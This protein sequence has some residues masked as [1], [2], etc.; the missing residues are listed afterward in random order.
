MPRETNNEP[1]QEMPNEGIQVELDRLLDAYSEAQR[2]AKSNPDNTAAAQRTLDLKAQLFALSERQKKIGDLQEATQLTDDLSNLEEFADTNLPPASKERIEHDRREAQ[3]RPLI[4]RSKEMSDAK[5]ERTAKLFG[6]NI[7]S[8]IDQANKKSSGN[9]AL[10][11][12][13]IQMAETGFEAFEAI[14]ERRHSDLL[15][16]ADFLREKGLKD[17][18]QAIEAYQREIDSLIERYKQ[19]KSV[20]I[21]AIEQHHYREAET[22]IQVWRDAVIY[23]IFD[24]FDAIRSVLHRVLQRYTDK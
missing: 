6:E 7:F 18:L 20:V 19:I 16:V 8:L 1:G 5:S 13:S 21:L 10:S 15:K 17:D 23:Q 11:E 3:N 12:V 2:E 24:L 22:V 9:F 14:A 4:L